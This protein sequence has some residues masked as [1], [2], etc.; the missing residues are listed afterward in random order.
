M[1]AL[2]DKL[3]TAACYTAVGLIAIPV[4]AGFAFGTWEILREQ[5]I[6]TDLS[7]RLRHVLGVEPLKIDLSDG[8]V[9]VTLPMDSDRDKRDRYHFCMANAA[10]GC[11]DRREIF[12][13]RTDH[14][15]ELS[16]YFGPTGGANPT[17]GVTI[18]QTPAGRGMSFGLALKSNDDEEE[19]LEQMTTGP[20]MYGAADSQARLIKAC[21]RSYFSEPRF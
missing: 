2:T 12:E 11:V 19:I 21:L 6:E 9:H 4:V 8:Q 3:K 20:A 13:V 10:P 7:L 16:P 15:L 18:G 5:M 1:S 17:G 14:N